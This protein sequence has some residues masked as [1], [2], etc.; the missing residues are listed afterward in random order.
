VEPFKNK[1]RSQ[2]GF[3]TDRSALIMGGMLRPDE[4]LPEVD[5]EEKSL[6]IDVND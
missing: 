4:T 2:P 1:K 6:P 3:Q 5:S